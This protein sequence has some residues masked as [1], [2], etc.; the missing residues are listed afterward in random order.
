[1]AATPAMPTTPVAVTMP[2]TGGSTDGA[3]NGDNSERADNGGGECASRRECG[4][5]GGFCIAVAGAEQHRPGGAWQRGQRR[6]S[7]GGRLDA[8]C[9]GLVGHERSAGQH[10]GGGRGLGEFLRR[11]FSDRCVNG[12]GLRG[13]RGGHAAA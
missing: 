1:M 2:S 9:D 13:G 7:G 8:R 11:R 12:R 10:G 6:R 5:G 3:G 4:P